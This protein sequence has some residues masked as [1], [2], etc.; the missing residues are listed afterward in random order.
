MSK[1]EDFVPALKYR[2]LTGWFDALIGA[3]T[4][5]GKIR[6]TVV[7]LARICPKCRVL[8]VGCGTGTLALLVHSTNPGA[9]VTGVDIDPEILE[10]AR[11]KARDQHAPVKF[12][13]AP[14]NVL[15][16][17][18]REFDAVVSSLVFHHLPLAVK[19]G[20]FREIHRVLRPGGVFVL[21]DWGKPTSPIERLQ[22]YGVQFLDGFETTTDNVR[23]K[24]PQFA[25][26]AGFAD[27]REVAKERTVYGILSFYRGKK[28]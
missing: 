20:A 2:F 7:E 10:I 8:D 6:R 18:D 21:A 23:G 4:R 12:E 11:N 17:A 28:T 13:N 22:F 14:A 27:F 9:R 5:E 3:T 1:K 26:E 25:K 24:L 19:K 16:F 15:P